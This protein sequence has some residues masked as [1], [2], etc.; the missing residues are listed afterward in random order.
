MPQNDG[1]TGTWESVWEFL[2]SVRL[3]VILLLSLAVTSVIGTLIPQNESPAAYL[4][5]Y[6][7]FLFRL[8]SVLDFFDMYRSWWFRLLIV[9]LTANIVVCSVDRL[10]AIGRIVFDRNPKFK[11]SRFAK[12]KNR[13]VFSVR[14]DPGELRDRYERALARFGKVRAEATEGGGWC[15][16]ADRGR[17]TRLGVYGVHLSIVVLLLGAL[18]GSIF[19]FDGFVTIPEGSQTRQIE[20]R[21]TGRALNLDFEIRCDDFDVSFY[22]TGAPREFR[23]TLTILEAGRPV[24][25]KDII[26]N[27]P[28][29]Y[30][31]VRIYQSS[32][33]KM[34]PEMAGPSGEAPESL[35]LSVTEREGGRSVTI[36]AKRGEAVQLPDGMGELTFAE[37]NPSFAFGGQNLG[38]AASIL[39][40][41]PG[42][43]ATMVLLP[44]K[45]PNFDRMRGGAL[46]LTVLGQETEAFQPGSAPEDRYYTGLQVNRDP[47]VPMVYAGF[48]LMI[49]GFVVTFFM[50]HQTVCIDL[51]VE[52]EDVRVAVAGTA[53]RNRF[54][55]DAK[56]R[57]LAQR[58]QSQ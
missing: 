6:G 49:A 14:A 58:L 10:S 37:Y 15:L 27:D 13:E 47:G 31:G 5:A 24:L 7:E 30:K 23:S 1:S 16:F 4:R 11:R 34:P 3:T 25:T 42:Q 8:F 2:A 19:G 53:N 12:L 28:L 48:I 54:G 38:A 21:G 41:R 56:V 57:S 32:Y 43:E 46:F 40:K 29:V 55:M 33:G 35:Q 18:V 9:A 26:V 51:S 20:L 22:D 45:F 39:L 17:W 50:S 44:L 52:G 36:T